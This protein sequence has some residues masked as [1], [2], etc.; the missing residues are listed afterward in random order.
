MG[1]ISNVN[2][3]KHRSSADHVTCPKLQSEALLLKV[4]ESLVKV[5]SDILLSNEIRE[6]LIKVLIHSLDKDTSATEYE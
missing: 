2:L 3:D 6:P 1:Y 5:K 4:V